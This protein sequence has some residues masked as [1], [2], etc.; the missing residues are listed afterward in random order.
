VTTA[1]A[2]PPTKD[3]RAWAQFLDLMR[4]E[5]ADPMLD[6][7]GRAMVK[8][9][10]AVRPLELR[11][12][13]GDLDRFARRWLM[14]VD[15]DSEIVPL[16]YKPAQRRLS[17]IV[18]KIRQAGNPVRARILKARREGIST[19]CEGDG[20]HICRF[21]PNVYAGVVSHE[22][23]SAAK[24]FRMFKTFYRELPTWMQIDL[25]HSTQARGMGFVNNSM[26][27]VDTAKDSNVG[28]SGALV[29]LHCSELAFWPGDPLETKRS[30]YQTVP[31]KAGT[32]IYEES[33]AN[34]ISNDFYDS[35]HRTQKLMD[36]QRETDWV[37]IFIPWWEDPDYRRQ[38][39]SRDEAD[40]IMT[41]L[42]REE[43]FLVERFNL[44]PAQIKWRRFAIEDKCEGDLDSFKQEYPAYAEEA[45]RSTGTPYFERKVLIGWQQEMEPAEAEPDTKGY[46][47]YPIR[48]NIPRALGSALP[49]VGPDGQF[50][51]ETEDRI[52]EIEAKIFQQPQPGT[53]Y[54]LAADVAEGI[55]P[56][57]RLADDADPDYSAGAVMRMDNFDIVATLRGRWEPDI[58]GEALFA[59]AK[60]YNWALLA[61]EAHS[62]GESVIAW[63]AAE[64]AASNGEAGRPAY[65]NLYRRLVGTQGFKLGWETSGKSRPTM[66][67]NSRQLIR[68]GQGKI[69]D[70]V[71][72]REHLAMEKQK[73]GRILP[74][75]GHDDTVMQRAIGVGVI[76]EVRPKIEDEDSEREPTDI[77]DIVGKYERDL[78]AQAQE[79]YE[80]DDYL[81]QPSD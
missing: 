58:Y 6:Q 8:A 77:R 32:T 45:F 31:M 49:T 40:Y 39:N 34:G 67:S 11:A 38:P 37:N 2:T 30:L 48:V 17:G 10:P 14:I 56:V 36:S 52:H 22:L 62:I 68:D 73:N 64:R 21:N 46:Q 24:I 16:H 20:F 25:T 7:A 42:D 27:E 57:H 80:P 60:L 79:D 71:W 50:V 63:V 18:A 9:T 65:P 61:I 69:P 19:F 4:R 35:W 76:L 59:L 13:A 29:W 44:T 74:R 53:R 12:C 75:R 1:L 3:E 26:L 41:H 28:R 81:E 33:T 5:A 51:V 15:K 47:V 66:L 70:L 54:V 72:L 43:Q 23:K 55:E 78:Y